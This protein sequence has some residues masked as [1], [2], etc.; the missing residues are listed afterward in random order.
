MQKRTTATRLCRST[1]HPDH[2]WNMFTVEGEIPSPDSEVEPVPGVPLGD[3]LILN[4]GS[5]QYIGA[6][7]RQ[8]IPERGP[9]GT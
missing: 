8:P 1:R 3:P 5:H 2:D 9:S 6:T 7:Y 4:D